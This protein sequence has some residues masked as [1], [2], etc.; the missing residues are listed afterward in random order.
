M[1]INQDLS[2]TRVIQARKELRDGA[3]PRP[4]V[5]DHGDNLARL[6]FKGKPI[7]RRA[8][9]LIFLFFGG[10]NCRVT[11]NHVSKLN[12]SM[13]RRCGHRARLIM[14]LSFQIHQVAYAFQTGRQL[15]KSVPLGDQFLRRLEHFIYPDDECNQYTRFETARIREYDPD[16]D[17]DDNGGY[18]GSQDTDHPFK[19]CLV[20]RGF[21]RS[22]HGFLA[23]AGKEGLLVAALPINL[24]DSDRGQHFLGS[25]SQFAFARA[26]SLACRFDPS[27]EITRDQ[28]HQ[29]DDRQ[30]DQRDNEYFTWASRSY[31]LLRRTQPTTCCPFEPRRDQSNAE[32]LE[33]QRPPDGH[34]AQAHCKQEDNDVQYTAQEI[35]KIGNNEVFHRRHI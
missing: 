20:P 1:P 29:W 26:Q 2:G 7:Q 25:R 13:K 10:P 32:V 3:F 17:P 21:Q 28:H 4:G 30:S 15:S 8:W 35:R 24:H 34:G 16:S 31:H 33:Q 23:L 5:T 27:G 18:D 6:Y 11:E 14:D 12:A 22:V 9:F 19:A